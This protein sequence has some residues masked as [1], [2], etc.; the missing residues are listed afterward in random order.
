LKICVDCLR[1][2][3]R[4]SNIDNN[5]YRTYYPDTCS[6]CGERKACTNISKRELDYLRGAILRVKI[7]IK[8]CLY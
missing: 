2:L 6:I 4:N 5:R 3:L 1:E 8:R 7:K